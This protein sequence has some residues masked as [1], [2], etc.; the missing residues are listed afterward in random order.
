MKFLIVVSLVGLTLANPVPAPRTRCDAKFP[1]SGLSSKYYEAIAHAIHSL[2]LQ[3]LHKFNPIANGANI[4][5]VNMNLQADQKV[6]EFTPNN[7]TSGDFSTDPMNL[8]DRVL[9]RVGVSDDGLGNNW[10]PLERLVHNFHMMDLWNKI[11]PVFDKIQVDVN[12][13]ACLKDVQESG[14]H[15]A[16]EW[17]AAHYARGTPITLLNRPIPV[18]NDAKTWTLWKD[19]LLHY[20]N[21][22]DLHD[23]AYFLKCAA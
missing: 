13:C 17:V 12:V 6:L 16:V 10:T 2:D 9:S 5:T 23:A 7:P 14:V 19:R 22:Q 3:A 11:K 8:V 15:G 20:Y 21:Q 18:L 1:T 4:P